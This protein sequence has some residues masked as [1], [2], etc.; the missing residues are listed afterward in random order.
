M[1]HQARLAAE[2][3]EWLPDR[4]YE[5]IGPLGDGEGRESVVFRIR[6]L[7]QPQQG[8][9]FA[10]KMVIHLVGERAAERAGHAQ[11]TALVRR[12][13][14]E[15]REPMRMPP[16]ECLVPVLHHYHSGQP[17]LADHVDHDH[18]RAVADRTLFLVT[19]LYPSGS[20]R[21]FIAEQRALHP[22]PPFGLGWEWFGRQLLRML[23][24]EAH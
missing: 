20:L 6:K 16:H 5:I 21:S 12:L 4:E 3:Q 1:P 17:R 19:P 14:A 24:A 22:A 18:R 15:W 11:S 13:G 2:G 8:N 10:L 9:E 23:R 7:Q